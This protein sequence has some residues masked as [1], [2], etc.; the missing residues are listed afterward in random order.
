LFIAKHLVERHGGRIDVASEGPGRGTTFAIQTSDAGSR[1]STWNPAAGVL[2]AER[3]SSA[4][5]EVELLSE[6][7]CR[8]SGGVT[9]L[10]QDRQSAGITG[11]VRSL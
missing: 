4:L 10:M 7:I 11:K 3:I 2:R 9:P 8:S 1:V 6:S 5:D